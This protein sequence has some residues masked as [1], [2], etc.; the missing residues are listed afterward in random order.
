MIRKALRLAMLTLTAILPGPLKRLVLRVVFG[1]CIGKRVRVGLSLIDARS[2]ILGDGTRI[3]HGNVITRVGEFRTGRDVRIG[4][5]NIIR[6]GERVVLGDFASVMR[7][8][9][10]NAIPD[11]DATT[12][13][14]SELLVGCGAVVVAGHRLDFTDRIVLGMNV[15]VAGRNSSLWTHNRQQ[16][17]PILIG[18][19]CY[20]GS[21]V[22]LAPGAALPDRCILGLGAVLTKAIDIPGSLV[23]GV[24]ARVVRPLTEADV[25]SLMRKTRA[26]IPDELLT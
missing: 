14:V 10:L 2:V 13:P 23:A 11:H 5:A 6:G 26:D 24:P 12:E 15:I 7:F 25:R 4:F 1:Y 16:T 22:R 17:A 3:G 20:L 18:D 21:E 8:N 9:V 19:F